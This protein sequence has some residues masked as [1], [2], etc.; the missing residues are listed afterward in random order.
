MVKIFLKNVL[1]YGVQVE[2]NKIIDREHR[3]PGEGR[4]E[5]FT[6]KPIYLKTKKEAEDHMASMAG[7]DGLK[8]TPTEVIP[9][10]TEYYLENTAR[11]LTD[12]GMELKM[13]YNK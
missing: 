7:W 5:M 4:M 3:V 11:V 6:G 12:N 10:E 1:T 8:V 13:L 2:Y 9:G